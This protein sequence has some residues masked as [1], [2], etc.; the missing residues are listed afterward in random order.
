MFYYYIGVDYEPLDYRN[1]CPLEGKTFQN[2]D[3]LSGGKF[4]LNLK[5]IYVENGV[6]DIME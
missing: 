2:V 4:P 5:Q 6:S 1:K 3:Y